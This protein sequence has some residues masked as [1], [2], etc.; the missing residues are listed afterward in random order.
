MTM[1]YST[2][3]LDVHLPSFGEAKEQ[4]SEKDMWAGYDNLWRREA[5]AQTN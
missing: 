1:Y 2:K 4:W 5:Q 3:I